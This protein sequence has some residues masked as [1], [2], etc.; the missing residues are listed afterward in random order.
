MLGEEN[1]GELSGIRLDRAFRGQTMASPSRGST[2]QNEM[3]GASSNLARAVEGG[4]PAVVSES[5]VGVG[6]LVDIF[7]ALNRRT[8]TIGGI[9]ELIR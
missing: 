6:H 1:S 5:L 9:H 8:D 2:D 7:T 4:L 3:V